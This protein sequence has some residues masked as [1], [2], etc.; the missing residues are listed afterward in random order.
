MR[1]K[2]IQHLSLNELREL[3]LKV[4][5]QIRELTVR[6]TLIKLAHTTEKPSHI[7]RLELELAKAIRLRDSVRID[8]IVD[9]IDYYLD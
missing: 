2:D 3:Q 5:S 8:E 6:R 9:D 7:R 1:M 4:D